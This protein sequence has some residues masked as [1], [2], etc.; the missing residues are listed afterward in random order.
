MPK[1]VL[2][3][4]FDG[5]EEIEAVT[6]IDLLRRA[7]LEVTVAAI[8]ESLNIRGRSGI[9]IKADTPLGSSHT[10]GNFDLLLIPGGPGVVFLR[11]DGRAARLA[12]NFHAAGKWI[13][14]IC[15]APLVLED[16]GLLDG[17]NFTAH[18]STHQDLTGAS[19]ERVVTDGQLITSR[20]AGT[21]QD[22]A[23]ALIT[24]LAGQNTAGT[25][26][27]AIMA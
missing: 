15:A 11:N 8:G 5:F 14:A 12:A 23:L 13:A 17:R 18:S 26:G 10:A 9:V 1:R 6:P 19:H 16:A 20:G 2:C 4:L 25:V 24:A 22:F 7:G 3:L 27:A 21:A